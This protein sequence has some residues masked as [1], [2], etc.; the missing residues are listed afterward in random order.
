ME[1]ISGL[2]LQPTKSHGFRRCAQKVAPYYIFGFLMFLGGFKASNPPEIN[3][4]CYGP[5]VHVKFHPPPP[6]TPFKGGAII[7][8]YTHIHVFIYTYIYIP[9]YTYIYT[10]VYIC[11]CI[12]MYI[13]IYIYI[14]RC[15]VQGGGGRGGP[16]AVHEQQQRAH[17]ERTHAPAEEAGLDIRSHVSVVQWH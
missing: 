12:H 7:Y 5:P 8:I 16:P 14:C 4:S 9:L 15:A 6:S 17:A 11:T 10:C 3:E 13:C 1:A 2:T